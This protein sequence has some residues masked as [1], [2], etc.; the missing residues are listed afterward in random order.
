MQNV[1]LK[2]LDNKTDEINIIFALSKRF[3]E[4]DL[5]SIVPT[6]NT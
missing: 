4:V 5:L 6:S 1:K 3:R 2:K